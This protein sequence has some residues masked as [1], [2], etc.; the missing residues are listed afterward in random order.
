MKLPQGVQIGFN[1]EKGKGS[2][3]L[4]LTIGHAQGQ[5]VRRLP[6]AESV[7]NRLA[8][9]LVVIVFQE[10]S[11]DPLLLALVFKCK[12]QAECVEYAP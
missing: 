12:T 2:S 4:E 5:V 7:L 6:V 9:C 3:R 10:M 11:N 8:I 1:H